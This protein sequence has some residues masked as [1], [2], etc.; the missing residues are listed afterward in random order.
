MNYI[1]DDIGRVVDR[2]RD[3]WLM[4]PAT[5]ALINSGVIIVNDEEDEPPY[6]MYGHR[7]EIA[8]RLN[9]KGKDSIEKFKRYPLIALR[10][11]IP[12]RVVGLVSHFTLNIAIIHATKIKYTAE[13]R[14][15]NVF[16]PILYPLYELFMEELRNTGGFWWTGNQERPEHTKIDRPYYGTPSTEGNNKSIFA[17]PLD[18]IEIIDL[19]I[20]KFNK[21]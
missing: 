21:C 11:D 3:R 18:A 17:D 9:L 4:L 7:K 2:V 20:S 6:Y 14:Y 1:V 10:L 13:E 15:T 19:R 12:E 8:N 5:Q 16:K